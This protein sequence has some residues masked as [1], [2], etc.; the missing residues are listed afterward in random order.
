M[1][2]YLSNDSSENSNEYKVKVMKHCIDLLSGFVFMERNEMSKEV[3][4]KVVTE[5][6]EEQLEES[7]PEETLADNFWDSLE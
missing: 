3:L 7:K 1:M 6:K 4:K 5:L 2:S